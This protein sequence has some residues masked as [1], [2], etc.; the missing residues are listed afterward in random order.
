M[1]E[2]APPQRYNRKQKGAAAEAAALLYLTSLGYVILDQNWRCRS[3]EL[4][5]VAQHED[6]LVIIEV[7]SRGGSLLQGTPAESVDSRK[8]R[9]VRRTAQLYILTKGQEEREVVFDVIT[10]LLNDDLS[11]TSLGHIREAF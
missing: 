8:I 1:R 3:G 2:S 9:Q 6:R 5:I 7:R 11:V 10:V 4:D